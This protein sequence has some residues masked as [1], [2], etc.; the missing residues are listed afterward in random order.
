MALI[1][2]T[3]G[4]Y[5]LMDTSDPA[6]TAA[7]LVVGR[8]GDVMLLPST[9]LPELDYLVGERLGLAAELAVLH[10]LVA[11]ELRLEHPTTTD[12]VRCIELMEQY[13]DSAIGLVDA[14]VVAIA[15]RLHITRVLT[16]DRRHFL[17]FRPRHAAAFEVIP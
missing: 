3:S 16:L 13:A 10:S 1:L 5:A 15:E 12:L 7:R 8:S 17:M 14:S 2:D 11:G 6:H 4:L 9:V